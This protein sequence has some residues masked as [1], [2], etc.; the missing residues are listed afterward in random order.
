MELERNDRK[1]H[2]RKANGEILRKA[3]CE[4]APKAGLEVANCDIRFICVNLQLNQ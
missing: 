2:R 3:V 1:N 4:L